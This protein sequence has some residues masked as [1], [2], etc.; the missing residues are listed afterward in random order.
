MDN[1]PLLRD[2]LQTFVFSN[3]KIN[4]RNGSN[5]VP[6][7]E[8]RKHLEG[9]TRQLIRAVSTSDSQEYLSLSP[10]TSLMAI[11]AVGKAASFCTNLNVDDDSPNSLPFAAV[12]FLTTA[13]GYLE[14]DLVYTTLRL[15]VLD[16]QLKGRLHENNNQKMIENNSMRVIDVLAWI[17]VNG[18]RNDLDNTNDRSS[19][20]DAS[21]SWYDS[22]FRVFAFMSLCRGI[23]AAEIVQKLASSK[24]P[25]PNVPQD[26]AL[27][28]GMGLGLDINPF[29]NERISHLA[30]DYILHIDAGGNK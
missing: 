18:A 17:C 19:R 2:A 15:P 9:L 30:V 26:S 25:Y 28:S 29:V 16:T 13:F 14:P 11:H 3:N 12:E 7:N 24:D 10:S 22:K 4:R 20:L 5:S 1:D 21:A 27:G 8:E 6:S 23:Q